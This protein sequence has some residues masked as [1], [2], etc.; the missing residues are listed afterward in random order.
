MS[1][2]G[3]CLLIQMSRCFSTFQERA[4]GTR[5][6]LKR[7]Y[8]SRYDVRGTEFKDMIYY[9]FNNVRIN[10]ENRRTDLGRSAPD[11]IPSPGDLFYG[12]YALGNCSL[13]DIGGINGAIVGF[14]YALQFDRSAVGPCY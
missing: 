7:E 3:C 9:N 14:A 1:M 12:A 4:L 11:I 2:I 6:G 10:I 8:D 5:K 13:S